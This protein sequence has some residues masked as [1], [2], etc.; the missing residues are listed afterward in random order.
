MNIKNLNQFY[1]LMYKI[2]RIRKKIVYK[3]FNNKHIKPTLANKLN[4]YLYYLENI[5]QTNRIYHLLYKNKNV[6]LNLKYEIS[7]LKKDIYFLKHSEDEFYFYLKGLYPD[8]INQVNE[9]TKQLKDIKFFNFITDRDGTINNY[10]GTYRSSIQSIYNSIFL[11]RFATKNV[12]NS[13][14]LTSAPLN[15]FGLINV[16]VNPENIFIYAGSN[17]REYICGN[18]LINKYPIEIDKQ[19]KLNLLN[20]EITK[21][22]KQPEYE[23]FAFI[24]S[25]LQFKF[26]QT[27]I[28]RQDICNSISQE[29]SQ[30]FLNIIKNIV[31]HIDPS[32]D[33]FRIQDTGRDIEII[34]TIQNQ[35]TLKDFD[36]GDGIIFLN[37]RLKLDI[38]KGPNLICGDTKSDLSMLAITMNK[39]NNTYSIFV[40]EDNELKEDV[41]KIC[42]DSFFVSNPDILV[43]ILNN[44]AA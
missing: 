5:K 12:N 34:L 20:K 38:E 23:I 29:K 36:K 43:A 2:K 25:G 18:G 6:Q 3:Y 17:G 9:I 14:I 28:A 33:I 21:L 44:L 1:S 13:I 11:T 37:K 19:K 42:P 31:M 27:T 10:C 8:F 30:N 41:R 35:S 39:R 32:K 4:K 24:G 26:G 7:E 22:I 40:T 16:S 15:N